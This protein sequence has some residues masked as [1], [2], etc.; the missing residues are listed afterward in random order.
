M[1]KLVH[2]DLLLTMAGDRSSQHFCA[3]GWFV[4]GDDGSIDSGGDG[5]PDGEVIT[6]AGEVIDATGCLVMPGFVSAH[7]HLWQSAFRGIGAD[8]TLWGWIDAY[9]NTYG[10][11]HDRGDFG[12]FSVY[13]AADCLRHGVTSVYN[14]THNSGY[15]Q[16]LYLEQLFEPLQLPVRVVFGWAMDVVKDLEANRLDLIDFCAEADKLSDHAS[17]L[18]PS[19]GGLG[20]IVGDKF[21]PW[22]GALRE[23]FGL[24][25]QIHYLEEP[26]IQ[27]EERALFPTLVNAGMVDDGLSFAHFCH[28]DD[29]IVSE[30]AGLGAAMVWNPMSN[31]RLGSG[32]ADVLH[33]EE[34]GMRCALGVDGQ[35]TA[36]LPDPF[37]NMRMGLY[38][39]RMNRQRSDLMGPADVLLMHTRVAAE[40]MGVAD[41]VGSLEPGRCADFLI[42]DP[43]SPDRGPV[44]DPLATLVFGCNAANIASVYVGGELVIEQGR[45]VTFDYRA[46]DDE[47]HDR[48]SRL[49]RRFDSGTVNAGY[50][51]DSSMLVREPSPCAVDAASA[52]A[53]P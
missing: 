38:A 47:V 26:S 24:G 16:E 19:L 1:T 42:V 11:F 31:G 3:P 21:P 34:L 52:R 27:V 28:A 2:T 46:I 4:V 41:L 18:G 17:F 29:A 33:Y 25:C 50:K 9:I 14:W 6:E 5:D 53:Q 43:R 20:V 44:F 10:A 13:G 39:T 15:D 36:D 51:G 40:V 49:R 23:E 30:A 35:S 45:A 22:E 32:L 37:E 12:A 7:N 48:I 8:K